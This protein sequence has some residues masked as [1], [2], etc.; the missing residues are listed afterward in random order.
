MNSFARLIRVTIFCSASESATGGVPES[1]TH[2]FFLESS[3]ST[4]PP[5][6]PFR[7]GDRRSSKQALSPDYSIA[8]A[9]KGLRAGQAAAW[10]K[11]PCHGDIFHIQHQAKE[12]GVV[13]LLIGIKSIAQTRSD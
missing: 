2:Q 7:L 9:A 6:Q 13:E 11:T 3:L 4:V 12:G 5:L 8:D 1:R 10:P